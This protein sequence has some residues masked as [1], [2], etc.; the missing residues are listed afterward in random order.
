MRPLQRET[1]GLDINHRLQ[2]GLQWHMTTCAVAPDR[3]TGWQTDSE[4]STRS[5][6]YK[7]RVYTTP[8]SH[9]NNMISFYSNINPLLLFFFLIGSLHFN[10]SSLIFL[11][12]KKAFR[13]QLYR[14]NSSII[15]PPSQKKLSHT[16]THSSEQA[17]TGPHI[18]SVMANES[19]W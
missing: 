4:N 5:T 18:L 8:P 19:G 9:E 12:K 17:H 6:F 15:R 2:R 13:M 1:A 7:I 3:H 16:H 14:S 10:L 11:G